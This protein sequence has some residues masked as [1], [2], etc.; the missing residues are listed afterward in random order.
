MSKKVGKRSVTV[1][2]SDLGAGKV[3]VSG[4]GIKKTISTAPRR[5]DIRRHRTR[6]MRGFDVVR[7]GVS[8]RGVW[9]RNGSATGYV[10]IVSL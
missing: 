2:V 8:R 9:P 6:D 4:K 7:R 10:V 5:R 1:K 3:T